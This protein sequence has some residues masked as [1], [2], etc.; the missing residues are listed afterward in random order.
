M[1]GGGGTEQAGSEAEARAKAVPFSKASAS[2]P[3]TPFYLTTAFSIGLFFPFFKAIFLKL[4]KHIK[5]KSSWR[6]PVC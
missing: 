3:K 1:T 4:F 5:S 6:L 2:L